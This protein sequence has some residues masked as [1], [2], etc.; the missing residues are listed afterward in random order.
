M[1]HSRVHI[2]EGDLVIVFFVSF[3]STKR[4][5]DAQTRDSMMPI[6][7]TKG[8]YLHNKYGRYEHDDMIGRKFGT[9]VSHS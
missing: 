1:L 4:Q 2:E 3:D 8:Q 6:T 9:K 5:A 7:V